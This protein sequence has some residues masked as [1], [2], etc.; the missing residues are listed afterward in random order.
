MEPNGAELSKGLAGIQK[1]LKNS[2]SAAH[3]SAGGASTGIIGSLEVCESD[4]SKKL[5]EIAEAEDSADMSKNG[6][7]AARLRV[8]G[9]GQQQ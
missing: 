9:R 4:F 1:A 7:I 8:A 3:G 2:K 6:P 5:A